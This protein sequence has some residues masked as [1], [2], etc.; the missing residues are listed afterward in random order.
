MLKRIN[1]TDHLAR[2]TGGNSSVGAYRHSKEDN[3]QT[4]LRK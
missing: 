2:K 4:N 3:I 1:Y